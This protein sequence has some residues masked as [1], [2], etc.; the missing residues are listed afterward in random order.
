M[1]YGEANIVDESSDVV[2]LMSIHK[3]K[4]LEFPIV[5]VAGM[6]KGFNFSD[7][8]S[9]IVI[10]PELG[11]GLDYVDIEKRVKYPSLL[12]KMIQQEVQKESVAEELRVL[13]VAMTRAKE[14]LIL[15]GTVSDLEK[16][17][18][19]C[20]ELRYRD[21]IKLPYIRLTKAKKYFDWIIPALYRNKAFDALSDQFEIAESNL[22]KLYQADVPVQMKYIKVENIVLKEINL[23]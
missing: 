9:N 2:R 10:H 1:D 20:M 11:V 7:A 12:K 21:E 17:I 15:T 16:K 13:Y 19:G 22:N 6:D 5:F 4:G 3:S 8:R 14:K 18:S 23:K